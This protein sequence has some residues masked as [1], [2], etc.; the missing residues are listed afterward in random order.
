MKKIAILVLLMLAFWISSC[1]TSTT[2]PTPT[3]SASGNWEAQLTGGTGPSSQLNFVIAFS[4][5]DTNGGSSQ[6]LDIS[7]FS[8][9]NNSSG[10]CFQSPPIVTGS[11]TLTTSN[12]N[13]VTGSMLITVVSASP[14][15]N[16][17]TLTGSTVTGT[18]SGGNLSNGAVSG[19]W[20]LSGGAGCTVSTPQP[21]TLCQNAITCSTT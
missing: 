19:T 8:F 3:T 1:G 18:A 2:P 7:G 13:Q 20:L 16:T 17:L 9:F 11:A 5:T 12:S 10:S 6:A 15:G 4:V 21:F 14:A